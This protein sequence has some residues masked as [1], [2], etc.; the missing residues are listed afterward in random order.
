MKNRTNRISGLILHT[1]SSP[2]FWALVL[3]ILLITCI[4]YSRIYFHYRPDWSWKLEVLEFNNQFQGSLFIIPLIYAAI[5]Y[6]WRG[7]L[8]T[9]IVSLAI[10]TPVAIYYRMM[11]PDLLLNMF[12]LCIPLIIVGYIT[13]L[14]NWRRKE[15]E[16]LL[17]KEKERQLYMAKVFEAHEEERK[18]IAQELHDDAIQCLLVTAQKTQGIIETAS[19]NMQPD[20]ESQAF[21]VREEILQVTGDLKRLTKD[22][23]PGILDN[24][25]L[26]PALKWLVG[27]LN[28][29]NGINARFIVSGIERQL[30]AGT[31]VIMFRIIQESLNNIRKHSKA[32]K[33]LVSLK[34]QAEN[35]KIFVYDN[36][37]GFEVPENI[38]SLLVKEKLGLIGIKERVHFLNGDFGVRSQPG[39]GTL[40]KI[41][42]GF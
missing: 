32:T 30:P 28:E 17:E 11:P 7:L 14:M 12:F 16:S 8:V 20:I 36:G 31:D 15:R 4:Y 22:L 2:H 29:D 38:E 37:S 42:F 39:K 27:R 25:G 40:L 9:L 34:F 26:I 21:I 5:I 18:L 19:T 13:L 10:T 6:W 23:R 1:I 24:L 41:E 33:V 35:L 3:I